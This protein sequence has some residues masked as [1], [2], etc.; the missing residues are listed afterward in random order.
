M[1]KDGDPKGIEAGTAEEDPK[2][3][4]ADTDPKRFEDEAGPDNDKPKGLEAEAAVEDP[5]MLCAVPEPKIFVVGAEPDKEDP[6]GLEV[7]AGAE[8]P[9]VLGVVPNPKRLE[10]GVDPDAEDDASKFDVNPAPVEDPEKLEAAEGDEP[11]I[12]EPPKGVAADAVV[13]DAVSEPKP[14]EIGEAVEFGLELGFEKP[15]EKGEDDDEEEEENEEVV[16][17][18]KPVPAMVE[19]DIGRSAAVAVAG[20]GVFQILGFRCR[21][22]ENE[23]CVIF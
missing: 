3:L 14:K 15:N 2:M 21:R 22:D 4:G 20:V 11:K 16:E 6:K 18:A 17:K 12:E 23:I 9:K 8:V 10:V 7:I 1:L 13:E 19:A 5:N